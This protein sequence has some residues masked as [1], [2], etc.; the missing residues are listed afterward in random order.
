MLC[1]LHPPPLSHSVT[2]LPF[3]L[4]LSLSLFSVVHQSQNHGEH[5]FDAG[6]EKHKLQW[7]RAILQFSS[8]RTNGQVHRYVNL[9]CQRYHIRTLL[10]MKYP[11]T[12]MCFMLCTLIH[13]QPL[14]RPV[15][16]SIPIITTLEPYMYVYMHDCVCDQQA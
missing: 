1:W 14:E 5:V 12:C 7:I 13:G 10:L 6:T 15:K 8:K 11:G 4:S 3:V 2:S 16:I 9:F